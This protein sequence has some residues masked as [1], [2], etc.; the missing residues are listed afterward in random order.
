MLEK[1]SVLRK[2]VVPRRR[3]INKEVKKWSRES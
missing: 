1:R 2:I 3:K